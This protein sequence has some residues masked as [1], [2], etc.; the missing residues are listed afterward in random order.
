M[1]DKGFA[2]PKECKI[3]RVA[4]TESTRYAIMGV[5]INA[6][7]KSLVAT[8]GR[9]LLELPIAGMNGETTAIVPLETFKAIRKVPFH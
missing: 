4:A 3:D 5:Q 1:S 8:D 6:E 2:V 7:R 9:I